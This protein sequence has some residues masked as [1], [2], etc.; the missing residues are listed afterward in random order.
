MLCYNTLLD[1]SGVNPNSR[2]IEIFKRE[3]FSFDM[4]AEDNEVYV[5]KVSLLT[6]I[7]HKILK[8]FK[9]L[10]SL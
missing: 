2:T 10:K 1:F 6:Q 8:L 7:G 4:S 5:K 3:T 9:I